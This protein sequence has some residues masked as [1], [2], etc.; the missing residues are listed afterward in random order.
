[1]I[2]IGNIIKVNNLKENIS[3]TGLTDDFFAVYL[4]NLHKYKKQHI[5]VVMPSLYEANRIYSDINNYSDNVLLFP[6]DDFFTSE[7]LSSSP[8]LM[9]TR[10]ETL[11]KIILDENKYIVV[12]HLEGLTHYLP[13]V[14]DYKQSILNLSVGDTISPS[15]LLNKL[16]RIGYHSETLVT[17][18]GE[19]G[20]RGFVVDVFPLG[21]DRPIRIEFFGDEIESIRYFDESTQRS[22]ESLDNIIIYPFSDIL[23][24]TQE[25][26][27]KNY[28]FMPH[29]SIIDFLSDNIVVFKDFSQINSKYLQMQEE[30]EEY[31]LKKDVD[32]KGSYFINID[33]FNFLN[34]IDYLSINNYVDHN[35]INFNSLEVP[36]FKENIEKLNQ[37]I[38][39]NKEK[40]ITICLNS[41]QLAKIK[42]LLNYECVNTDFE[43]LYKDEINLVDARISN[44]FIYDDY[45]FISQKNIFNN[46]TSQGKYKTK[47]K[48]SSKIYDINKIDIGD[49]IVHDV[50]GIGIYNGIKVLTQNGI[51]KDYIEL[52]YQGSD[53]LYIPV[54][55]IDYISKFNGKEGLTPK[56]SRLGG[57]DWQK[58]KARVRGKV[59]DIAKSLINVYAKRQMD[60]GFAFSKDNELQV[61]FES[62][63][64]HE[65]TKDQM[66]V[67]DQ[68]KKDMESANPMDRLLCGDVGYGK[69]EVAFRAM[70]KAVSNSKQVLY[71]CPT[72]ILSSQ[73][74]E[75]ALKR[76]GDFP[77]N[78]GL[79]NRFTTV[80]EKRR[81]LKGL[82]DGTMDIVIGTHSLLADD[83]K[84]KNLGLLVIDEEQHKE[85]IKK[86]KSNIDVLTLTATPIPRTLQMSM[87][88][89]RSLS[90]IET[91]PMDRY[92][93]QTY[94]IE[95]SMAIIKDAIYKELSR[96]GQVF[97]L[98]NK[99]ETIE[100]EVL[101]L[102]KQIPE[103]RIDYVHGQLNKR[104]I[105]DK[106]LKYINREIDVLVCTTIIETGLDISNANTLIIIDADRF[107][108]SQL[109]QLRGRVGRSNRIA[110]AYL[111]YNGKKVLNDVAQK[112]LKVIKTF[113]ELGSGF[114]I[115]TRD[116]SI[117]GAGDILG[118]EQAGF[119]DSVGIDLYL[120]ILNEEVA[121]LRGESIDNNDDSKTDKVMLNV[122]THISD[123]YVKDEDLKI[124]IHR[125][126]N[127][128]DSKEKYEEVYSE[129]KDRFGDVSDNLV[130]YMYEEWFEKLC[131]KYHV[132][133]INQTKTFVELIFSSEMSK[134]IDTEK[135]FMD[136][137]KISRMFRFKTIGNKLVIVLDTIKLDDNYIKLL[138]DILSTFSYLD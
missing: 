99:V 125:L 71:L 97:Y 94:V 19:Y 69:T 12:T 6:M 108:L 58:T 21:E 70:F 45:L 3:I 129:L 76:F 102:Q 87:V 68:I 35:L 7:A 15:D 11:N 26:K 109:Y 83:V 110:Y 136:S 89:L 112:R 103:A 65:L 107:G 47:F 122:D 43:H 37:Y 135:L 57:T 84:P 50:H 40:T 91:P 42:E 86:Y 33:D 27:S 8:D 96:N 115:A 111:M 32:F 29:A 60:K 128:I 14:I 77:V 106:M 38:E 78:I 67:I 114:A 22:K 92:P 48:F 63:F 52:L 5:L 95:E 54:E 79:L 98:Y 39:S 137:V 113:T 130:S 9:I 123:S 53:K 10:L 16:E 93:V 88:G 31:R 81:I 46:T 90:L 41:R 120:K 1:M 75:N 66:L 44:G 28:S 55:K 18:T 104:E 126:I 82:E 116:L 127:S 4:Y 34:R 121:R 119:I 72:T 2:S 100:E 117:R 17:T 124:E 24:D 13:S 131:D 138:I 56:I 30:A 118:S 59:K 64:E 101:R 80:K 73:H 132:D 74:Y 23:L 62:Q 49:Y 105:E 20:A 25:R 85:K 51:K 61:M 36:E 134:T 133:R